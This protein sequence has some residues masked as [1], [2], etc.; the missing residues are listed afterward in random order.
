MFDTFF[1]PAADVVLSKVEAKDFLT[2]NDILLKK[3][4]IKLIQVRHYFSSDV[5]VGFN[6]FT[7]V[8]NFLFL[9]KIH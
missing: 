2:A 3:L 7:S 9:F 6:P 5:A 8:V 1:F 4:A